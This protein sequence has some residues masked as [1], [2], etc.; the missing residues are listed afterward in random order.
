[1]ARIYCLSSLIVFTPC[2]QYSKPYTATSGISGWQPRGLYSVWREKARM[3][4]AKTY[5]TRSTSYTSDQT[6]RDR[7]HCAQYPQHASYACGS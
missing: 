7:D 5:E 1:M 3:K 4:Q 2:T 6:H